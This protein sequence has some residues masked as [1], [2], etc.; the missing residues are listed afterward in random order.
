MSDVISAA[1]ARRIALAAQGFADPRPAGR[2]DARHI[3]RV[4]R[5]VGLLQLD[6][7]NVLCRSHYLPVLSRCGPYPRATLDRMAGHDTTADGARELFEYWAHEASL[8]P[9][10]LHRLLRWRMARADDEAWAG[11]V[12]QARGAAGV[13]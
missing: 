2:V 12:R 4:L 13:D 9:L 5:R 6:S 8:L 11:I 3:R 10:E 7:I 1:A